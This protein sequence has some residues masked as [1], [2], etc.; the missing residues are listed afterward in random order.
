MFVYLRI[1][2]YVGTHA[3]VR[4]FVC[5]H[6]PRH[7]NSHYFLMLYSLISTVVLLFYLMSLICS[8]LINKSYRPRQ[9]NDSYELSQ[10][11]LNCHVFIC[12]CNMWNFIEVARMSLS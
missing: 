1:R 11:M 7:T 3:H 10:K 6:S 2:V 9:A 12:A 8:I 5:I 4:R